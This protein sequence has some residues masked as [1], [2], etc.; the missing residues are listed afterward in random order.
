[1]TARLTP[2][3]ISLAL[4]PAVV[5]AQPDTQQHQHQEPATETSETSPRTPIPPVTEADREAAFP[6][7]TTTPMSGDDLHS[8]VLVDQLEGIDTAVGLG[9]GWDARG[10]IGGDLNRAWFRTEGGAADGRLDEAEA[11]LLYGRAIA[12]WWDVVVGVRQ[13]IRPGPSRSWVAFGVQGLAPY[14]FEIEATAYLGTDGRTAARFEAEYELLLT[15]RLVLQPLVELNLFGRDDLERG[16]GAGLSA[17]DAGVRLRY[18]IRRELAPYVGVTWRD[19]FGTTSRLATLPGEADEGARLVAG[20][21][22]WF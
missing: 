16:I 11:H 6:D 22:L 19:T 4:L 1:M 13:D 7:I 3:L 15:N 20:L 17:V 2:V 18:E 10:W 9:I 12:R 21:R 8:F 5:W 14:W